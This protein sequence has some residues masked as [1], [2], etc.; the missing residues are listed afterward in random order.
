MEFSENDIRQ[1]TEHIWMTSLGLVVQP[2]AKKEWAPNGGERILAGCIQITGSWEGA[3]ALLCPEGL[4][5]RAAAIMFSLEPETVTMD[6]AQDA[7]GELANIT[8]GNIKAMLPNL[9]HLSLPVVAEETDYKV[10]IPGSRLITQLAFECQGH[11]LLL[12][13]LERDSKQPQEGKG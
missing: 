1:L 9:C 11:P 12:T 10:R 4:A 7:L 6:Q 8:G 3:V 2:S 5:R 13:L